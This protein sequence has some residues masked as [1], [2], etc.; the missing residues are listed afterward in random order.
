MS[1]KTE[2]AVADWMRTV[3]EIAVRLVL[4]AKTKGN[5][6]IFEGRTISVHPDAL[7][8]AGTIAS[9]LRLPSALDISALLDLRR[10]A[11]DAWL[12]RMVPACEASVL[13][14][15]IDSV[16]SAYYRA[17][18]P[19]HAMRER[20]R[21]LAHWT[22]QLDIGKALQ[23]DV[24]WI[25]LQTGPRVC[26]LVRAVQARGVRVVYD[27]DD[28]FTAIPPWSGVREFYTPARIDWFWKII[29]LADC[30][31]TTTR[32]LAAK[33]APRAR[34]VE[35]LPNCVLAK[36]APQAAPRDE[37][38][39]GKRI[40][41]AGSPTHSADLD[42]VAPAIAR[43]LANDPA[44]RFVCFGAPPPAGLPENQVERVPFCE[45]EEYEETLASLGADVAIAPLCEHPF[46]A[47]KSAI[48]A[49]E[50]MAA[51][52]PVIAS[53]VGEYAEIADGHNLV[54]A[55]DW[56]S[57]LFG[58]LEGFAPVAAAG[59]AWVRTHRDM[60]T[61]VRLWEDLAVQIKGA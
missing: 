56:E 45:F 61:A 12:E 4:G 58:V 37:R 8:A 22:E 31:T 41:W 47:A 26:D 55:K 33:L 6:V 35:V 23:F 14:F 17:K 29:E 10:A 32:T 52:Y 11:E 21:V 1:A 19:A 46:N 54:L 20:G 60:D 44:N 9:G 48:K 50:C 30:V 25:Q 38:A 24:L 59:R 42:L 43:V 2:P 49:I 13:F 15:P 34:R 53:A 51:G 57:S 18:L 3:P 28:D 7:A 36:L 27:V 5:E 16:G 39:H 40:L